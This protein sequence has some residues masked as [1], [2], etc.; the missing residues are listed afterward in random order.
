[1]LKRHARHHATGEP[2]PDALIERLHARAPLQPGLRDGAL[3]RVG[4]GR[5]G[6]ARANRSSEPIDVVA[7]ERAELERHRPAAR[8]R[9]ATTGCRTSSTCSRARA[10]PPATTSTCGPRCSTPTA[11]TPSSR[12]AIRST[13][14]SRARLRR[15]I[16]S[17]GNSIEPGAA[18]RAFRGRAA[19]ARADAQAARPAR[20][21]RGLAARAHSP[22]ACSA[23]LGG[24]GDDA[25]NSRFSA[26]MKTA[27][28]IGLVQ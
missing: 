7:F 2:I 3:R 26:A 25:G 5:H 24:V 4:A 10:T 28:S 8:R 12:P 22:G 27:K 13:R 23:L 19:G 20:A 9:H 1:M 16:Y 6:G 18:Y 11:S 17:S 14:R 21:G 15:F